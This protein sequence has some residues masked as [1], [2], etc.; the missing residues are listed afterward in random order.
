MCRLECRK[1]CDHAVTAVSVYGFEAIQNVRQFFRLTVR[2][3]IERREDGF[4]QTKILRPARPVL[5][6]RHP[7]L[8]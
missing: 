2:H 6:P 8:G 7:V 5:Y 3:D 1:G 4:R